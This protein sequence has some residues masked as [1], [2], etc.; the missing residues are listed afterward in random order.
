LTRRLSALHFRGFPGLAQKPEE[1]EKLS[2]AT[3]HFLLAAGLLL[4]TA[5]NSFSQQFTGGIRGTVSDAN[6]VVPGASVAVTNEATAVARETVS[7]EVGEYNFPALAPATYS[8]RATLPGYKTFERHGVRIATQQFVTL[9]L[10]LEV[11]AVEESITVTADAPLIET[12]NASHGGV[13]D[14]QALEDLPAPGRNAFMIGVTVPTVLAVGEPRFN[15]Q[16]DQMVSSQLSLGGGGVQANN[17]TLDGVPITDMRGFPVL[18]PTIEAIDDV[19]VQVHT[20]DAEMGRTGGGVFNTTAR[21]GANAFHGTAFYQDRPVWGQSLEYFSE[22][23]GATKESSG[24]SQSFYHLYGGGVGGPIVKNRTFF[25]GASEG[26]RD[27]VIQQVSRTWP[28]AR[29][30][31]GDFSTTTL[32]GAPVRIFNPYCRDGVASAKCPATGTGSLATGGEFTNAIIPQ[33][34]PAANPVAFKMASYWPLPPSA[35]ENSLANLDQTINLPDFADM[36]TFKGEHKFSDKSSLSGLF[37]YNQTKEPAASPVP[38]EKSFL[39]QGA[40]WLIRHPKVFVLNNTNVLSDTTVVSFRYGYSVFPDGRNCRGG[41]PGVGCFTDGLAS[42]GFSQTYLNGVDDTAANLFPSVSFQNFSSAG[43]NLNTAPIKWESPI[44]LNGALSKLVGRHTWK[45]GADFRTMR[46]FTTLLNNTAGTFTFQNLFTAGPNRVGGYDFA[47]FLLGAATTGSVDYNRGDGVY[48][49]L[50]GGGYVQDDWRVSSRFTLNYGVRFEHESGLRER[51]NHITVGFDPNATS[52]ALQA[53]D[54]AIR[55]N[56]YTGPPLRGGLMFAGVDGANDYQGNPPKVKTSPRFGATWAPNTNT[57]VRGGYGLFYAPWQYTQQSHGTIGFTRSTAMPQSAA[58]S[59]VPLVS[60]DNPFPS[61]LIAP[62]GSSLGILTGVG[63]NIDFIDQNKGAPRVHQYAVDMQRQLRGD[64]A[65]SV[66][67]IGST[68][69]DIGYGGF[70]NTGIEINQI[71]PAT[72]PKD[73][74]GRWDVAALRRSVPNPFFGVPGTGE[75]GTSAT[76]LA[77]QLLRPF[78]QFANVTKLQ[79]TE[80]GR[81]QYHAL[82]LK[83]DKRSTRWGGHFNYVFSRMKDNQWGQTST[84]GASSG[85]PQNY[86]DLDA[87]YG[88]STIDTPH[89]IV[90]A[91]VVRIPGPEHGIASWFLGG[92]SASAIVE[93]VSGPPISAYV[94]NLSAANLGLFNGLQRPNLTGQP[95]ETTGDDLDRIATADHPAAA[96]ISAAGFANPGLGAYGNAPRTNGDNRYQFRQNTDA[97][98]TKAFSL[99][100]G[101]SGEARFELLNLTNTPKFGGANTDISSSAFGLITTSRGFSRILQLSFRYKF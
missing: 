7:N 90:L 33:N 73:A 52:P 101:Q 10:T 6:G 51:D 79:M 27:Q 14:R 63:G 55:R 58:E 89:R 84:Y 45:F 53:I 68:G 32:N 22:K 81:R 3:T 37:I 20:F 74:S 80:G 44:T 4:G 61:G 67:Y 77:G 1:G 70:T 62:T 40:N 65:V 48:S 95:V 23:R 56:G 93:Y 11:G 8:I 42:L 28:S 97:V 92:W 17:Y 100:K 94:T 19:K 13:L 57:V 31:V 9:D 85:T 69:R 5:A 46:L 88:I 60:L 47:S 64:M 39:E 18:N 98:F 76:I 21:S 43:Q 71:D 24:L 82:V 38:D 99:P 15:R 96:W 30:R 26:Y 41:S 29:Q 59:A 83:L 34:H 12:S 36:F 66:G 54:A 72:L 75:L 49:L 25:W 16:Q 86:Y 2:K 91:P 50:Y 78:P 87:E 35:N